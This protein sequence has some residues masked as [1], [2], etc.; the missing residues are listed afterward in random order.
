MCLFGD[1]LR[2]L[3]KFLVDRYSVGSIGEIMRK[4]GIVSYTAPVVSYTALYGG[5]RYVGGLDLME[6]KNLE[7][8]LPN[9]GFSQD[10]R[11]GAKPGSGC[12][13]TRRS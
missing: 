10:E 2:N 6:A 12:A 7:V 3:E 11:E 9:A 8:G 5:P 4:R 13:K 1:I